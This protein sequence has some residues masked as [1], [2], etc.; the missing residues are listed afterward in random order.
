MDGGAAVKCATLVYVALKY[1]GNWARLLS[2][3]HDAEARD[4]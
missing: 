1:W 2:R 4:F 3:F